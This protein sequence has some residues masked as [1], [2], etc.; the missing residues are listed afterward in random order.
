MCHL[1]TRGQER[2][3]QILLVFDWL[4]DGEKAKVRIILSFNWY[5]HPRTCKNYYH[6]CFSSCL[7]FLN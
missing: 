2:R 3:L 4:L 6:G 7:N 5:C 1:G